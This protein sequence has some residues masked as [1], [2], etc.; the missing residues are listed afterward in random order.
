MYLLVFVLDNAS[1]LSAVLNAWTQAGVTGIT[2]LDST[3]VE[4]VRQRLGHENPPL[5]MGFSRLLHTA[6]YS[7]NTL[8]AVVPNMDTVQQAVEATELI[9]GD[10]SKAHTGILFALPVAAAWGLSKQYQTPNR[11]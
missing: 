9:T 11:Q 3:G 7:H 10:L 2:L 5:F 6:Q 1:L 4:R 8:F